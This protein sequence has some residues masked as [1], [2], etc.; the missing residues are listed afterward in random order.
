VA[1]VEELDELM[2]AV[3]RKV[4]KGRKAE[5]KG[6]RTDAWQ[7]T[8][9]PAQTARLCRQVKPARERSK[10]KRKNRQNECRKRTK[11]KPGREGRLLTGVEGLLNVA[12][13]V[14]APL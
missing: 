14:G 10:K 4:S 12:Q 9:H 7:E 5:A 13:I 1:A 8:E 3:E 6:E 11:E 2:L